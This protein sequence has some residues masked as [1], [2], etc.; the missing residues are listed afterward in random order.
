MQRHLLCVS[1]VT[2]LTHMVECDPKV[3]HALI[4][5]VISKQ[6]TDGW[7]CLLLCNTDP[8]AGLYCH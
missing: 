4:A 5:I 8:V 7:Y 1:C 3:C 6:Y 2:R